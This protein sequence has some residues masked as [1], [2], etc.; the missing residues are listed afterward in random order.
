MLL[1]TGLVVCRDMESII[2]QAIHDII[3]YRQSES[4]PC[5]NIN[6]T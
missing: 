4:N 5:N 1:K 2:P 6:L 3:G